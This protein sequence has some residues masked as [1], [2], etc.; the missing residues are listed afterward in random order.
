MFISFVDIG[1]VSCVLEIVLRKVV[2]FRNNETS[3]YFQKFDKLSR[4][5]PIKIFLLKPIHPLKAT[6]YQVRDTING[7]VVS[8]LLVLVWQ[9]EK[10]IFFRENWYA[11]FQQVHWRVWFNR[12]I[13]FVFT[14][15]N[16]H[17]NQYRMEYLNISKYGHL[18]PPKV[19]SSK[20]NIAIMKE[21]N[22]YDQ[23]L[24]IQS[25]KL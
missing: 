7:H 20:Q 4:S 15:I 8:L 3:F 18:F 12:L 25:F 13:K 22:I 2:S 5:W 19:N 23:S 17:N 14:F 1:M 21:I 16:Y 9:P 11:F 10:H 24:C 6:N